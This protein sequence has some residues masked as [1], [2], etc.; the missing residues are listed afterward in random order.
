MSRQAR[1]LYEAALTLIG[2]PEDCED[3]ADLPDRLCAL[4]N[5][6]TCRTLYQ[7]LLAFE[8]AAGPCQCGHAR[9]AHLLDDERQC[10]SC[11]CRNFRLP[12]PAA[13]RQHGRPPVRR[14]LLW[15]VPPGAAEGVP[16]MPLDP[17]FIQVKDGEWVQPI[18]KGYRMKCC[19]CGLVHRMDFRLHR[20]RIQFRAFR[21]KRRNSK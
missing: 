21:C 15:A 20:R 18:R 17:Q 5:P 7:A 16:L 6:K 19:D 9:A 10:T 12:V 8:D 14:G 11:S 1:A 3:C 2:Y 13:L 4:H